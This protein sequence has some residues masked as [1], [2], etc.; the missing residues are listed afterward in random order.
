MRGLGPKCNEWRNCKTMVQNVKD[1]WTD[2]HNE[3]RSGRNL[4][5]TAFHGFRQISCTDLY[6]FITV[7]LGYHKFLR[8]MGSKNAHGCAQNAENGLGFLFTTMPQKWQCISQSQRKSNRWWN[9]GFICE[10][11]NQRVVKAVDVNIFTKQAEEVWTNV[12]CLSESWWKPFS[13]AGKECWWWNSCNNGKQCH[14][15]TAKH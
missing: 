14:K 4:W 1:R 15:C 3:E 9:L 13:G 6:E 5:K 2:V 10:C 11:W 7:R 8:T 12:V